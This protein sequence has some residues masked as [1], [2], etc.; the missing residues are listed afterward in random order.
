MEDKIKNYTPAKIAQIFKDMDKRKKEE[1]Y[2]ANIN[3]P[4][5][6]LQQNTFSTSNERRSKNV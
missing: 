3:L 2:S 6:Q 4:K 5:K 1:T